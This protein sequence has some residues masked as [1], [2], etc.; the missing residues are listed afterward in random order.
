MLTAPALLVQGGEALLVIKPPC[1]L[2]RDKP[3]FLLLF[4]DLSSALR[5]DIRVSPCAGEDMTSLHTQS[6][7]NP[8]A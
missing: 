6:L 3:R 8:P 5:L 1:S 7:E 2:A 4:F